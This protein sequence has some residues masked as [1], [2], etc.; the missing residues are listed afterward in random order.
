MEISKELQN[1]CEEVIKEKLSKQNQ[2]YRC[3]WGF[4]EELHK[5]GLIIGSQD[6]KEAKQ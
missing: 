4:F 2:C 3:L 1:Q 6:R 5:S